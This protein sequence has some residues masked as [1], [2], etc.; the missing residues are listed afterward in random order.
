[1][2]RARSIRSWFGAA[3]VVLACAAPSELQVSEPEGGPFLYRVSGEPGSYLFGT[4]HLPDER[5]LALSPVVERALAE[6][7]VL[8]TEVKM[9]PSSE[10]EL[11]RSILGREEDGGPAATLRERLSPEL[12]H[13]LERFLQRHGLHVELFDPLP[14]WMVA[15]AIQ[16]VDYIEAGVSKPILDQHLTTLA[17]AAGKEVTALEQP[18]EQLEV[19]ET[20]DPADQEGFLSQTLDQLEE[21]E[22]DGVHPLELLVQAYLSGDAARVLEFVRPSGGL[23]PR[24]AA[25]MQRMIEARSTVMAERIARI[26]RDRP[27]RS[28]FFAVGVGHLPGRG[29]VVELL[30]LQGFGVRRVAPRLAD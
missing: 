7:S 2:G 30:R 29:G 27:A 26:L 10:V 23:S 20:L 4:I 15:T 14:I 16:Q 8:Y 12:H 1:M 13:R 11:A 18:R 22:R 24:E 6:A 25:L 19:F 28:H 3:A 9:D 5:V 21:A 17:L